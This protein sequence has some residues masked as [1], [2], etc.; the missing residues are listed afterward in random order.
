MYLCTSRF[1]IESKQHTFIEEYLKVQEIQAVKEKNKTERLD[2]DVFDLISDTEEDPSA[3][4][5]PSYPPSRVAIGKRPLRDIRDTPLI[6]LGDEDEDVQGD[7]I[8][9]P[10]NSNSNLQDKSGTQRRTSGRVPKRSKR[11]DGE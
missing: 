4:A 7:E 3:K 11:N 9:L 10:D 1:D 8:P 5:Q 2:N 6:E